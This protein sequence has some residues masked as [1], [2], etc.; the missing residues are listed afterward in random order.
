MLRLLSASS[1]TSKI[2]HRLLTFFFLHFCCSPLPTHC[3]VIPRTLPAPTDKFTSGATTRTYARSARRRES[4]ARKCAAFIIATKIYR[5]VRV[6][7][8]PTSMIVRRKSSAL[9]AV[10][11]AAPRKGLPPATSAAAISTPHLGLLAQSMSANHARTSAIKSI[12]HLAAPSK[13]A[14]ITLGVF[15]VYLGRE[16]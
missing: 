5:P 2:C 14:L 1:S 15:I 7:V 9:S 6:P 10:E 11:L 3:S 4:A 8:S 13:M 12:T 16:S